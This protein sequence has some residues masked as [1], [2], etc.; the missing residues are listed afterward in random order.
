MNLLTSMVAD[1]Y[2][3]SFIFDSKTRI[4]SIFGV[5]NGNEISLHVNFKFF[6]ALLI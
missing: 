1:D 5:V 3:F 6:G 4:T 2:V